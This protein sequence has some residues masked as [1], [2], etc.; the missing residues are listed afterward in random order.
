MW[1]S[2]LTYTKLEIELKWKQNTESKFAKEDLAFRGPCNRGSKPQEA[3]VV[4][5]ALASQFK[6]RECSWCS[7]L[8]LHSR[9][10][11]K[12]ISTVLQTYLQE[13]DNKIE[14]WR[15]DPTAINFYPR[16]STMLLTILLSWLYRKFCCM[17]YILILIAPSGERQLY[18]STTKCILKTC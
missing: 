14:Q 13:S 16:F 6:G 3:Y 8:I 2:W 10:Q 11:T 12:R 15:S 5:W 18:R 9:A 1:D 4:I 7:V 17:G